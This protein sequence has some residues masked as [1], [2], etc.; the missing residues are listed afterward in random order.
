MHTTFQKTEC[1]LPGQIAEILLNHS[2]S[3]SFEEL[4][5]YEFLSATSGLQENIY[6]LPFDPVATNA[7]HFLHAL[8]FLKN[9][10]NTCL[11]VVPG[12]GEQHLIENILK[13]QEIL[14]VEVWCRD[15]LKDYPLQVI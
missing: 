9:A 8:Q 3:I 11:V 14:G 6:F 15:R 7:F 5:A 1:G 13:T 12:A 4:E 2:L 10:G